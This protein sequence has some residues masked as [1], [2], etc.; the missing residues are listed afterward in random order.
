MVITVWRANA[1]LHR[2]KQLKPRQSTY[3]DA[4][5]LAR[6]YGSNA[7]FRG[8]PCSSK[9]C[10]FGIWVGN[11]WPDHRGLVETDFLWSLGIRVSTFGGWVNVH[12]GRV[13]G[14]GFSVHTEARRGAPFGQW[15][16]IRSELTDHFHEWFNGELLGGRLFGLEEHPNHYVVN[17]HLSTNGGGHA[18]DAYVTSDATARQIERAFDYRLSCVSSLAG[19]SDLGDLLPTAWEDHL[20]TEAASHSPKDDKIYG[21]CPPRSLARLARD[22]NDVAL[23]EVKR[24]FPVKND[25]SWT[26]DVEFQLVQV[27][28]G[29]SDEHLSQFPMNLGRVDDDSA[30]L[31]AALPATVFSPGKRIILF[32]KPSTVDFIPYP[33]CE[34]VPASEGNLQI[35]RQTIEQLSQG[36]QISALRDVTG[37]PEMNRSQ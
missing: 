12:E 35:V 25:H 20:A 27:L 33:H 13:I 22:M 36:A 31:P 6:D 15:L 26:Q 23:V 7:D 29:Q 30:H 9:D 24:V 14:T 34:V 18:L 28:K 1:L 32:L 3:E 2:I 37:Q 8:Q 5:R 11:D 21:P 16:A 17:P 19:C 10:S 4:L